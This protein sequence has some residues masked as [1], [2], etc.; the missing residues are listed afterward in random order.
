MAL[1]ALA[2][3]DGGEWEVRDRFYRMEPNPNMQVGLIAYTTSPDVKPG[4]EVPEKENLQVLKDARV[5]MAL[6]VDWIRFSRPRL[7][8]I[9]DWYAQ[10]NGT[11]RLA[12]P[13][14]TEEEILAALGA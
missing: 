6:E 1:F 5:D 10:V 4:P 13:N 3:P 8:P 2:R 14:L 11:N 12:N 9:N 7:A